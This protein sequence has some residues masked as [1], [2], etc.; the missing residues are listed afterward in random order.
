VTPT[1]PFRTFAMNGVEVPW[2]GSAVRESDGSESLVLATMDEA[3]ATSKLTPPTP[4]YILKANSD[5][6]VLD[7]SNTLFEKV[8]NFW[9]VRSIIPFTHP[10]TGTQALWFCNVGRE[11]GDPSKVPTIPRTPGI[12][13]EQD[14]MYVMINGKLVDRTYTLPQVVDYT[15]GCATFNDANGKAQLVK[16]NMGWIGPDASQQSILSYA[17]GKWTA[18][19]DSTW[20]NP[21]IIQRGVESF[22]A[23]AGDFFKSIYGGSPVFG[24]IQLKNNGTAFELAAVLH[25]PDLENKGYTKVQGS[26]SGDINNDGWDDLILVMSADGVKLNPSLSGAKLALFKNDGKGNLIY[27]ENAFKDNYSDNDFGLDLKIIDINFD[28]YPDIVTQGERYLYGT[29]YHYLKTDK[30]FINDGTGKFNLKTIDGTKLNNRCTENCQIGIYFLKG[31]DKN[32]FSIISNSK[33]MT[34][35]IFYSQIVTVENPL[36]FK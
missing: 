8:P 6:S 26:I 12:W 15:H 32:S 27:D 23:A 16:N 10:E 29:A 19:F 11:I 13:G 17:N 4:V 33:A 22:F 24:N 30:V 18:I 28:G 36:I 7:I 5:G 2:T 31:K 21:N 14:G 9:W 1:Q 35:R 34:G 20:N 3:N 25:A